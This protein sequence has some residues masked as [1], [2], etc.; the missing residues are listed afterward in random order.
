MQTKVWTLEYQEAVAKVEISP[1]GAK[2]ITTENTRILEQSWGI[3][4]AQIF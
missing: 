2:P 1:E 3:L 4:Y